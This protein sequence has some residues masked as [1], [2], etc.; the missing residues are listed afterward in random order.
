MRSESQ[1]TGVIAK[2]VQKRKSELSQNKALT[3]HA[4]ETSSDEEGG[5]EYFEVERI[6]DMKVSRNGRRQFFV[7]PHI[8][9]LSGQIF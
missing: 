7:K 5:E 3:S 9:E 6:L 2:D 4:Y 8:L 1:R